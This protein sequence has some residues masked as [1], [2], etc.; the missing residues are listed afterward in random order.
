[1]IKRRGAWIQPP[2]GQ[3]NTMEAKQRMEFFSSNRGL[4]VRGSIFVVLLISLDAAVDFGAAGVEDDQFQRHLA[5][6]VRRAGQAR[7]VGPNRGLDPVQR[8]FLHVPAVD[9]AFA[10]SSTARLMA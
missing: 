1:M 10:T 9:V 7:I 5:D 8:A 6:G 3:K 2:T 4:R